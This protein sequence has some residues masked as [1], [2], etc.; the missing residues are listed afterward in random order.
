MI[1]EVDSIAAAASWIGPLTAVWFH[2]TTSGAGRAT[3]R[4][5]PLETEIAPYAGDPGTSVLHTMTRVKN[6]RDRTRFDDTVAIPPDAPQRL[7]AIIEEAQRGLER[8]PPAHLLSHRTLAR[9]VQLQA[10]ARDAARSRARLGAGTYGTCADCEGPIS[11]SRLRER[12]WA[13]QC[14]YCALDI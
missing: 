14:I 8:L 4:P 5:R 13:Q 6:A 3:E 11:L 2:R 7:S 10:I 9:Q 1:H 12:P